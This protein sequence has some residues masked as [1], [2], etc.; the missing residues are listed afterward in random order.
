MQSFN[1]PGVRFQV[2]RSVKVRMDLAEIIAQRLSQAATEWDL[3]GEFGLCE[4]T[5]REIA[6]LG[7]RAERERPGHLWLIGEIN[8]LLKATGGRAAN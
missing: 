7:E 8:A 1:A 6:F 3:Q 4:D 2:S 5:A